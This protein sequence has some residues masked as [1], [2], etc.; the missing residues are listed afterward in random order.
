MIETLFIILIAVSFVSIAAA[1]LW[2]IIT[3]NHRR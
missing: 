1:V 3:E 2:T